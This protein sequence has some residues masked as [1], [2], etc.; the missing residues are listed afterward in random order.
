ALH[1]NRH[2]LT[3]LHPLLGSA[4]CTRS[5]LF[6]NMDV[7]A[8]PTG[9]TTYLIS[10]SQDMMESHPDSFELWNLPQNHLTV[11][12]G[13]HMVSWRMENRQIYHLVCSEHELA[14]DT[15]SETEPWIRTLTDTS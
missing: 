4:S 14:D 2:P 10:F 1:R 3:L 9:D 12:S 5:F 11:G 13:R 8:K 6:P 15:D 7:S